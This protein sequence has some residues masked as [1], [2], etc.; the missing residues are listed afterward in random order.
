MIRKLII[1]GY[2]ILLSAILANIIV[3]YLNT[4]TWYKFIQQVLIEGLNK[5]IYSQNVFH[6]IWLFLIY[7]LLLAG[8]YILGNKVYGFLIQCNKNV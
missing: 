6:I 4:C 2:F 5:T 7:P 8:A 3:D 1:A